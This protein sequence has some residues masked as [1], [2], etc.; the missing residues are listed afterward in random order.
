MTARTP[1]SILESAHH[2]LDLLRKRFIVDGPVVRAE[3]DESECAR[4]IVAAIHEIEEALALL[5]ARDASDHGYIEKLKADRDA[6]DKLMLD[7][8]DELA[9]LRERVER[10][11]GMIESHT[12]SRSTYLGGE[13]V[14]EWLSILRGDRE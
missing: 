14:R 12:Q 8:S 2:G 4:V 5:R 7:Q 1:E 10:A 13:T 6:A 3:V 9:A 11:C